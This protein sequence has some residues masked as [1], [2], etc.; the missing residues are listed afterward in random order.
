MAYQ[1]EL[2]FIGEQYDFDR[3]APW[4]D[5]DNSGFGSSHADQEIKVF[6][7]NSFDYPFVHGE[8]FRNNGLGFISMSD[9]AFEQ[10]KFDK[11]AFAALDLI[12]GEEK[13]VER[14]YG[15]KKRDFTI[16]TPKMRNAISEFTK[17]D[18]AKLF[19]SGAYVGTDLELCGDSLAGKFAADVLHFSPMTNH[20]SKSG[21][22]YP[23]NDARKYFPLEISFVQQYH[24]EIYK[25]ESP[26]AIE[27]KGENAKVL[28][29]YRG[30][31]KTAG[32]CYDGSYR[33][34][35]LGFPFETIT[36]DKQRDELIG[37]ILK[38]WEMK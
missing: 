10:Q 24:P 3:K 9:E 13:T 7:G 32:V 18:Q 20:A 33:T 23:V 2:C 5:D 11:N 14:F 6:P 22:I 8:S 25:V 26:G 31:N 36:T 21:G 17:S 16:F 28:F 37:Q 1:K 4:K 30:D 34:I 15:F 27:P 29:R 19:I 35:V 38:Y 12:F